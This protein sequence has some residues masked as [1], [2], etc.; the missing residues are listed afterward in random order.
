M[1]WTHGMRARLRLLFRREAEERMEEEMRFHLEME[2]EK[3]VREGMSPEAARRRARLAFGGVEGHKEAMRDGRTFAWTSSLPLDVKLGTRMLVKYPGLT[4]VGGLGM[5]IA[6]AVAAAFDATL[7][8]ANSPLPVPGGER[9]VALEMW[10]AEINNQEPRFLHDY[11]AWK[12]GLRTVE[13]LGAQR[14]ISRNLIVSGGSTE[15]ILVAE[16]SASGFGM[17]DVP[18]L[19][20]R[21]LVEADESQ[22]AAPV[23]VLGYDLWKSRFAGDPRVV[24]REVRLGTAVH[25]VVG[26]M[27]EGFGFP[28]N[29]HI[30]TPLRLDPA[31]Y[32]PRKGPGIEAFGRLAPGA[33]IE[34]ARAELAALGNRAAAASPET[35][36]HLRPR[37][38]QYGPHL[39]DDFQ[40]WEIP[41]MRGVITLLLL[42]IAVNVAVLVFARTATRT[43]EITVRSAL[44]ASRRRIVSQFFAEGTILAGLSAS[45]GIAIAA[46]VVKQLEG[47]MDSALAE[48]GGLPFWMDFHLSASSVLFAV[49]LA[50]LAAV[51]VGVVPALRAT[52]PRLDAALR[53]LGGSTGAGLGRTWSFLIV[54]QVAFTM[55]ILPT[56]VFYAVDFARFGTT[57]PGFPVEEYLSTDLVMDRGPQG[58]ERAAFVARY[59][60]HL[61]ELERRLEPEVRGSAYATS[62]PG[63]EPTVRFE[64]EGLAAAPGTS[65]GLPVNYNLVDRR[66]FP[67]F[68]LPVLTGR[69]FEAADQGSGAAS[70]VVN[71]AFVRE[72][73]GGAE[74]L[75]RRVRLAEGYRSG[76]VM[77]VPDGLEAD[78]WYEI[79]GVVGD[80]P[81]RAV[82]PGEPVAQVYRPLG[83]AG[84][85]P[86]H[87]MVHTRGA[88]ADF[89][90]RLRQLAA[91]V[92]PA[93][94]SLGLRPMEVVVRQFQ[95]AMRMAALGLGLLTGSVLLLSA[96]GI[97]AMMSFTVTRRRR[98]I[99]LRAALGAHPRRIIA[100]IFA[101]AARQLGIG[102]ALGLAISTGMN[103]LTAGE[104]TGGQ[105]RV[106]LPAVAAGI[107]AVGL[108][109]TLGPALRGLRIQPMEALKSDN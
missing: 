12:G 14:T 94:Q 67:T 10:D 109:A 27:P 48:M 86:L 45:I 80:L 84:I 31:G 89:G 53:A 107:L 79:V 46:V 7:G 49:G 97:Y 16:M 23:V 29:H 63:A 69:A 105:G 57:D 103:I 75:G 68:R 24:G 99:G 55:A 82:E 70:V 52:G 47:I 93:L 91:E 72:V 74:A 32:A 34:E 42:I 102:A 50:M 38:V 5:A 65:R 58:E 21:R 17:V 59:T 66:Y 61:A 106:V 101:R 40:G 64:V 76:G 22:G 2:T 73:L 51:I 28:L 60:A 41:F 56:T 37:V 104:I 13:T 43:G 62:I 15:P 18:P 20:G 108:L 4:L 78:R 77:Q 88:P 44:G 30:W 33:T 39:M 96:A 3:Y 19:L 90:P 92:D 85:Y 98:E 26:V 100:G 81:A 71:R 35:H 25:T 1:K 9:I 83:P 54:A 6:I 11:V 36:R 95:G 87:L 8:A